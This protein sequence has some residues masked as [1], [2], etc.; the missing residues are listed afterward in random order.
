MDDVRFDA[1][2]KALGAQRSRRGV[3]GALA[4]G[5]L[6]AVGFGNTAEARRCRSVGN[7]CAANGDCCSGFCGTE[8]PTRKTCHCAADR[9][10]PGGVCLEEACCLPDPQPV[11]CENQCGSQ[12]NNCQQSVDCGACCVEPDG[13]CGANGECCSHVCVNGV[14]LSGKVFNGEACDDDGDCLAGHCET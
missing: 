12:T 14:C 4:G 5:A 13:A 9:D 3:L 11:T 7:I 1:L 2:V 6:A 8:G 10:C